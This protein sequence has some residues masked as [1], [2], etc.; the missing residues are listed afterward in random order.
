MYESGLRKKGGAVYQLWLPE[1]RPDIGYYLGLEK[2]STRRS[3]HCRPV[4]SWHFQRGTWAIPAGIP[5]YTPF[6]NPDQS[7]QS[8][9]LHGPRRV[10]VLRP[11]GEMSQY[12]FSKEEGR[13]LE[14]LK[15][16]SGHWDFG[17]SLRA[18]WVFTN[19]L[20]PAKRKWSSQLTQLFKNCRTLNTGSLI[21]TK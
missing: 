12:V 15:N 4:K 17:V 16:C 10:V 6:S 11:K 20:A 21:C 9:G 18:L 5:R 13:A 3:T 7:W 14:N 19:S 8:K 1:G 2:A